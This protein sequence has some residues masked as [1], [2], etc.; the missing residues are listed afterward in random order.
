MSDTQELIH[1]LLHL[2]HEMREDREQRKHENAILCRLADMERNIMSKLSDYLGSQ[3]TWNARQEAS[4]DSIVASQAGIVGDVAELVRLIAELQN[5]PG[6]VTPEDAATIDELQAKGE[7]LTSKVEGVASA[8]AAL[9]A[10]RPPVVPPTP[11]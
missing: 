11:A 4:V 1:A 9:D 7:A 10:E 8:L 3:K 2:T 5:S 6:G